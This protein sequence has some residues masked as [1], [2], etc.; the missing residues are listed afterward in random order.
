MW[1]PAI[2]LWEPLNKINWLTAIWFAA[3]HFVAQH[4]NKWTDLLLLGDDFV[5]LMESVLIHGI[6]LRSITFKNMQISVSHTWE[7]H[8]VPNTYS[9]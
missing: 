3:C 6:V 8:I 9:Q 2:N 5:V 7:T 1:F 4:L